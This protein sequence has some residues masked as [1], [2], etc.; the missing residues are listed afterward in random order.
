MELGLRHQGVLMSA[1]R[2]PD[3]IPK[4]HIVKRFVRAFRADTLVSFADAPASFISFLDR[5]EFSDLL[6]P[7][8]A[9]IDELNLHYAMHWLHA[10]QVIAFKHPDQQRR[11][12]WNMLYLGFVKKLHLTPETPEELDARLNAHE[13][14]FA[15]DQ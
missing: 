10:V 7:L 11:D 13:D 14:V 5:G 15:L 2:G 8:F 1:V 3:S 9:S 12:C 6:R 4:D